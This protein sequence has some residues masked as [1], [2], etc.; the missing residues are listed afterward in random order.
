[1]NEEREEERG[2]EERGGDEGRRTTKRRGEGV[3]GK[4]V[5]IRKGKVD[6]IAS[7]RF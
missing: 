1:M 4:I 5:V 2:E 3:E 6:I 7:Y